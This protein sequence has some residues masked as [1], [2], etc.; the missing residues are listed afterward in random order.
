ML[1]TKLK[2]VQD[3]RGKFIAAETAADQAATLAA[4][5]MAQMLESRAEAG[6]PIG[7]G[8]VALAHMSEGTALMVQARAKLVQAHRVMAEMPGE[9][10]IPERAAGDASDCPPL[11]P[12]RQSGS[13]KSVA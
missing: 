9:M 1:N 13:L 12:K 11:D 7:T 8:I 6:L 10:G 3:V 4:Q 2:A 5:C